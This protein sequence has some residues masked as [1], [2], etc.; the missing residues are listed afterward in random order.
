[1]DGAERARAGRIHD[2][3]CASE[4]ESVGDAARDHVT[5]ETGKRVLLPPHVVVRDTVDHRL[6]DVFGDPGLTHRATPL[7]VAQSGTERDDQ[8]QRAGDPENDTGPCAVKVA[9]GPV[10]RV[11]ERRLG[12]D[13]AEQLRRIRR[14]QHGRRDPEFGRI[15]CGG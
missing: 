7:R 14:L 6:H 3:V 4:I 15:E 13:Q 5:E 9:L 1:M 12:H 8:L 10:T 11:L 2:A